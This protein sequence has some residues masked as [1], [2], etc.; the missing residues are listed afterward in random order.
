MTTWIASKF[1]PDN[2]PSRPQVGKKI[3]IDSVEFRVMEVGWCN[4]RDLVQEVMAGVTE[5]NTVVMAK[6]GHDRCVLEDH[7]TRPFMKW[8]L[9]LDKITQEKQ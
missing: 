6:K 5:E 4:A 8:L 1:D 9:W 2:D 3:E 7:P